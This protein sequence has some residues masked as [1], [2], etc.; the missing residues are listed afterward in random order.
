MTSSRTRNLAP[1]VIFGAVL[2]ASLMLTPQTARAFCGF[3]VGGADTK[4]YN[5]ATMVVLMRDGTRTVLSMQN[6]YQGPPTDFAMVVPVPVVLKEKDVKTL[7]RAVFDRVDALAAPRLVEYWEQDPCMPPYKPEELEGS[8]PTVDMV[9]TSSARRA[10][11]LGVTIEAKFA[12]GEY[13]ILILGAKDSSGLDTWLRGENYKIPGGAEAVLRPYVQAGMK[14]FVAK[15]DIEKVKFDERGQAMLSPLRFHY[16]S[17]T[18]SLPVRLGLINS[19]GKQDLIVHVL[20]RQARYEAANYRNVAIP[21]NLEVAEAAR[22][23]FGGFYAALFDRTLAGNPGAVITE[24]AWA[25]GSCDPC[26]QD[27][28]NLDELTTLGADVLPSTAAALRGGQAASDLQWQLPGEFVLTRLH[29]RYGAE[30]LGED[31]VFRAAPPIVG[32]REVPGPE[33]KLEQGAVESTY[34]QNNF[35]ARYIIRH[36]W[37]GPIECAEPRRG[38]WGGPPSGEAG[39]GT[40]VARDLAFVARDAP[41]STFLV[42]EA[43]AGD[44]TLPPGPFTPPPPGTLSP[45]PP[46]GCGRCDAGEAEFAGLLG[47]GLLG[48][49][50]R[51]RRGGR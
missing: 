38:I 11:D 10:K 15:I 35:Q 23:A 22:G 25:A 28:L 20:A 24:Y 49:A 26:P 29:A 12:V 34:G 46:A 48:L 2:S 14:F 42:G 43:P 3:Y 13:Q 44:G 19:G 32:G 45:P 8:V 33:G 27:P 4:L 50:W 21:T 18:F 17:D 6:N 16:D 5:N 30:S 31:L 1:G 47:V 51:R 7:D 40:Q 9:P 36:P 39:G 37:Q 41:L